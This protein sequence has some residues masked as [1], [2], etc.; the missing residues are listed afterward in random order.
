MSDNKIL[1]SSL[2]IINHELY[3]VY[4]FV[5]SKML[6]NDKHVELNLL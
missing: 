4:I 3:H 6:M 5:I 1:I 2:I